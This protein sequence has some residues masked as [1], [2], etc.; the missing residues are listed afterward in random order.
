VHLLGYVRQADLPW[1]Y[2][3]ARLFVYPS[4]QEGFGFPPLE[5]MASGI[6]TI[7]S[8]SS[9]LIEN[10]EGAAELVHASDREGLADAMRRLLSDERLRARRREQGLARAASFR[11]E[12]TAQ[13]T[14]ACYQQL[15]TGR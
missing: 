10:L 3:G 13:A 7:A 2:A 12:Q 6:P 15:A 9:S 11:W 14:L 8:R 5:A 1:L 4:F